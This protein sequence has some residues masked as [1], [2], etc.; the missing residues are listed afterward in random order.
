MADL[1]NGYNILII[2]EINPR[3]SLCINPYSKAEKE[4]GLG[5]SK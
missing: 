5:G 4:S 1:L 2:S 3:L